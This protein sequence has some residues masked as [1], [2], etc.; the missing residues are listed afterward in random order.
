VGG[1]SGFMDFVEAMANR[2][3][4]QHKDMVRW[5]GGPFNATDFGEAEIVA[6]VRDIAARRKVSL[7]AFARSRALRLQ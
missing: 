6:R 4:P 2:R 1:P 7:E 5:Y 3:H